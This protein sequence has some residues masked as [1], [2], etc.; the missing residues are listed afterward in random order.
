MVYNE[1]G[2]LVG[3]SSSSDSCIWVALLFIIKHVTRLYSELIGD[4]LEHTLLP[5]TCTL[6]GFI[7]C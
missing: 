6:S 7:T 1:T 2:P 3:S 5:V 4:E